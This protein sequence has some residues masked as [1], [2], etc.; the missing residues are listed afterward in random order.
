MYSVSLSVTGH[1]K[2]PDLSMFVYN[3]IVHNISILVIEQLFVFSFLSH[4]QCYIALPTWLLLDAKR[5]FHEPFY[6]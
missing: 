6:S 4:L 1:K 2:C 5:K 3:N